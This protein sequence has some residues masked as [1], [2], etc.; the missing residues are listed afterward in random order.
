MWPKFE[1]T[2][3]FLYLGNHDVDEEEVAFWTPPRSHS[4][5]HPPTFTLSK[6]NSTALAKVESDCDRSWWS[7]DW[8]VTGRITNSFGVAGRRGRE[9][10]RET[11]SSEIT[12][13]Y[14]TMRKDPSCVCSGKF[15]FCNLEKFQGARKSRERPWSSWWSKEWDV[16]GR[17]THSFGVAGRRG[18]ERP[19]RGSRGLTTWSYCISG[20]GVHENRWE[21]PQLCL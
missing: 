12:G 14:H 5:T 13:S 17:T 15:T 9:R 11:L 21:R 3:I 7:K 19:F 6:K 10:E 1:N 16:T 18:R 8:D 20:F 2:R 4:A